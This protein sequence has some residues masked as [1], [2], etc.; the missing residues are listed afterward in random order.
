M[1]IANYTEHREAFK[2]LLGHNCKKPILLLKGQSGMGKSTLLECFDNH[3]Q[4]N[5]IHRVIVDL[6]S[7][8]NI[9]QVFLD[10][11]RCLG[12]GYFCNL[13]KSINSFDNQ[14]NIN[15]EKNIQVGIGN[16]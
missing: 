10:T 9:M 11:V 6:R 4:E 1:D 2:L 12:W 15:I 3:I 5:E 7:T 8:Y 16:K 14:L 13:S